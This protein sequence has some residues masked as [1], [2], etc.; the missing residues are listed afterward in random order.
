MAD[1][2]AT[3]TVSRVWIDGGMQHVTG[4][5]AVSAAAAAYVADG[6]AM[7][8]RDPQI[9]SSRVPIDVSVGGRGGYT[10]SYVNGSDNSDGLLRIFAQT[11]VAAEDAPLGQ[12]A[13]AAIPAGVSG[14]TIGFHATFRGQF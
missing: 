12:L 10:Y 6:I 2:V 4:T 14:D 5:V 13:V 11:N 8:L 1:A 3:I 9:K 7:S